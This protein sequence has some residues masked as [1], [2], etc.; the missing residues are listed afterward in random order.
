MVGSLFPGAV[1]SWSDLR[2]ISTSTT[3]L[4][5]WTKD[6]DTI[7]PGLFK[8]RPLDWISCDHEFKGEGTDHKQY[9]EQVKLTTVVNASS[10]LVCDSEA[11]YLVKAKIQSFDRHW[12]PM[13]LVNIGNN[14]EVL[15]SHEASESNLYSVLSARNIQPGLGVISYPITNSHEAPATSTDTSYLFL[16]PNN[17]CL[18]STYLDLAGHHSRNTS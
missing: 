5:R 15:F 18:Y 11:V 17:Q 16:T 1:I 8:V 10:F 13:A 7:H 14:S 9:H 12:C 2:S 6:S 3:I 4:D